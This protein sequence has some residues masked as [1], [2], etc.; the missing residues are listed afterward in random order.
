MCGR[1]GRNGAEAR[2]HLFYSANKKSKIKDSLLEK[3]CR[4]EDNSCRRSILLNGVGDDHVSSGGTGCCDTCLK[5]SG[6]E[7]ASFCEVPFVEG[8][9]KETKSR[10]TALKQVDD[11]LKKTLKENLLY[12][13]SRVMEE[14][15]PFKMLGVGFVCSNCAINQL[16]RDAKFYQGESDI[17]L[18]GIRPEY[19]KRLGNIVLNTLRD[20]PPAKR[21]RK[22]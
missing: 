9:P 3:Y 21:S 11:T 17:N 5:N 12:E 22:Q 15:P 8:H 2:A 7:V 14:N 18:F 19:R 10:R 6:S 16:C 20:A 1:A 13:R 4:D